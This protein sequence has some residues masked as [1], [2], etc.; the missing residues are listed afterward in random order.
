MLVC[1][2]IYVREQPTTHTKKRFK[3]KKKKKKKNSPSA[4]NDL[5]PQPI[6]R[7]AIVEIQAEVPGGIPRQVG[8][9]V[10]VGGIGVT[11]GLDLDAAEPL[12]DLEHD[13]FVR[14][15]HLEPFEL[16]G[17]FGVDFHRV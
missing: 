5:A 16:V 4:K 11:E 17:D 9:K 7:V 6:S 3:K 1:T 12:V 8:E 13:V 15:P 14:R 10:V 2:K